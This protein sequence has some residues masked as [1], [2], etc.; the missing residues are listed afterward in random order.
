MFRS[1]KVSRKKQL[2]YWLQYEAKDCGLMQPPMKDALALDFL[3]DYL[4]GEDWYIVNPV[5]H[6]QGNTQ[7][8]HEILYKYSHAYRKEYNREMR[9]SRNR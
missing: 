4:L 3:K 1:K 6:E 7:L 9:R 2:T 5:N 8:V